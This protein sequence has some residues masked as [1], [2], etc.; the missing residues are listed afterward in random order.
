MAPKTKQTKRDITSTG[1]DKQGA[2]TKNGDKSKGISNMEML[3]QERKLYLQNEYKILTEHMNTYTRML[4]HYL[5]ENRLLEKEAQQNQ[6]DSNFYLSYITNHSWKCENLIITLNDQ[7][8][9]NLS[10]V[11]KEQEKTISRYTEK[12]KELRDKLTSLE[13]K[14]DLISKEVE[15]LQSVKDELEQKKK[16]KALEKELLATKVQHADQ[17]HEVE[18]KFLRAKADCE[19]E[20]QQKT[21]VLTK[22]AEAAAVQ[23]LIQY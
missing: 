19:T 12:E 14:C 16:V 17:V 2:R 4:E 7:Y 22:T 15:D 6:E 10:Q 8:H 23:S 21:Q 9:M 5:Q 13:T 18:R 20:F 1:K 3:A 11:R